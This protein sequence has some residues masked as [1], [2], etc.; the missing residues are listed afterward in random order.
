MDR[1]YD[2]HRDDKFWSYNEQN[3]ASP[4][5]W[6]ST[7]LRILGL[8]AFQEISRDFL[9]RVDKVPIGTILAQ[10][11]DGELG[12]PTLDH[13]LRVYQ[14]F[15]DLF[16]VHH[17][18]G[19]IRHQLIGLF[20][21]YL[22]CGL[23]NWLVDRSIPVPIPVPVPGPVAV[24]VSVPQPT[25]TQPPPLFVM[26]SG[27]RLKIVTAAM[28]QWCAGNVSPAGFGLNAG[29]HA[30][31]PL[32]I[33]CFKHLNEI[34]SLLL[35]DKNGLT[36]SILTELCPSL[37]PVQL[38]HVLTLYNSVS[39]NGDR[40][41]SGLLAALQKRGAAGFFQLQLPVLDPR[42]TKFD[43]DMRMAKFLL[44]SAPIPSQIL[45]SKDPLAGTI[46]ELL[47]EHDAIAL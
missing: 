9:M 13:F 12:S 14:R 23:F 38:E 40:V 24:P 41:A 17:L 39:T 44:S 42:V 4:I 18:M 11:E 10:E 15:L 19:P 34:G 31:R 46:V 21:R 16:V 5:V 22:N 27:M 33:D 26:G 28:E 43:M 45:Q 36:E 3:D 2:L 37:N 6:F 29:L 20:F 1:D 47:K 32:A 30:L 7:K 8:R 35:F 25:G